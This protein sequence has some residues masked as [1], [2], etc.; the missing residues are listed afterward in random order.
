VVYVT[1]PEG[2]FDNQKIIQGKQTS[3]TE[4]PFIYVTPL[5][6][7]LDITGNVLEGSADNKDEFHIKAEDGTL[8]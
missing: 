7:M 1:I 4:K 3:E 2:N 6:K 8:V 5:D